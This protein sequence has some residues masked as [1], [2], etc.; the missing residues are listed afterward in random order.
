M[1]F[2]EDFITALHYSIGISTPP[3]DQVRRAALIWLISL[4]IIVGVLVL[5]LSYVF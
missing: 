3:R 2:L 1:K 4:V 5:L